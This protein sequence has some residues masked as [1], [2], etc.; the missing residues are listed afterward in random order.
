MKIYCKNCIF[1][2]LLNKLPHNQTCNN[3]EYSE[4]EGYKE[5]FKNENRT[6]MS[7]IKRDNMFVSFI[8]WLGGH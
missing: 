5:T 4:Q 2:D 7:Y 8:R 6:C 3:I 1:Y